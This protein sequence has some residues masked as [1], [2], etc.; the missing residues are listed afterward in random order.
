MWAAIA[1]HQ[2]KGSKL[3]P[4]DVLRLPGDREQPK[5]PALTPEQ[6]EK[7]RRLFARWDAEMMKQRN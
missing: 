2:R 4:S 3:K 5:K 1:P 6:V 7:Q